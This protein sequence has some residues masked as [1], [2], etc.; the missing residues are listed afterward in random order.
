MQKYSQQNV[1]NA[2]KYFYFL[3]PSPVEM[4]WYWNKYLY[5]FCVCSFVM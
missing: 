4:A 5:D 2:M 1:S 3:L